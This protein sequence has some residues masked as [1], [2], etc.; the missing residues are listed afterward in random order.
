MT[1]A[2][3]KAVERFPTLRQSRLASFDR[4]AL[5]SHFDD[6]YRNDWSG[7]PQARGT[8]FHRV[9][10]KCLQAMYKEGEQTI[11]TDVAVAILNETLRQADVD[12]E[13]P[14]C[15]LPI[16]ERG[17]GWIKCDVGHKNKS[18]LMNLPLEQI[19][20]LRWVVVKWATDNAFDI[21]NLVDVEKR[22]H[23]TVRYPRP[24]GGHDERILTGALDAMFVTGEN[25]S[26]A[27]VLDWKDTW[28]LPS[29]TEVGFDGYF[30]QRFYAWLIFRNF[31]TIQKV[32]LREF[33][34]RRSEPREVEVFRVDIENIEAEFSALAERF[35]RAYEE[36][37][38]PPSPGR[39]CQF[40]PRPG[41][42]PIFP[43]VRGGGMIDS[44]EKAKQIAREAAVASS[45][46]KQRKAALS[47]WASV[48]GSGDLEIS[49]HKGRRAWTYR[50]T[51]RVARPDRA[52]LE[53]ALKANG[54]KPLN[55]SDLDA[56]YKETTGTR[57][58]LHPVTESD[59]APPSS[60]DDDK[61][62]DAL[63]ESIGE[64]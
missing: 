41:K 60:E 56:L 48:H 40:C 19:R 54:G 27:V 55:L 1:Y 50:E 32:I 25:D 8:I 9:A 4:C 18:S 58:G 45:A 38:W 31:P 6:E 61:L 22:L 11:P 43:G 7:H 34:V 20:D 44:P 30:Q 49:S 24:D 26:E 52:A 39:H 17:K 21:Q 33:Y 51:T 23:A 2:Y 42:C 15:L 28:D 5:S 47:A 10:A 37:N 14:T 35:D 16:T 57:F 64:D 62:M 63:R 53:E 59:I 13:C 46:L 36:Q 29:P 12:D 3:P